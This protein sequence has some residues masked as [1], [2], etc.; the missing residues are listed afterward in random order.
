MERWSSDVVKKGTYSWD[1]PIRAELD[2]SVGGKTQRALDAH[3]PWPLAPLPVMA[4]L[5][6]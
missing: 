6:E 5:N 4:H 3:G 1:R 2:I